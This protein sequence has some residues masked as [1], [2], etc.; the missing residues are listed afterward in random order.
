MG[1]IKGTVKL[2]NNY[3]KFLK[4]YKEEKEILFKIF[5][6][7][8]IIIEHIG[9]TSVEGLK[10]KPII[11]IAIGVCEFNNFEYY[12][13]LFKD[14]TDY[15]VRNNLNDNEI[16][17][18]KGNKEYTSVLIH[19]MELNSDRYKDSIAFRNY[20][21]NNKNELLEYQKLKENLALKYSNDRAMY[22]KS[23]NDFIKSILK[24][25]KNIKEL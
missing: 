2:E 7:E 15:E 4:E 8:E 3:D 11:D 1:L 17:I 5:Q 23:K 24:K 16:L 13:N 21:R 19:L 25:A 18:V 14:Y 12:K 6:K 10:A 22:T 20:L 9:S